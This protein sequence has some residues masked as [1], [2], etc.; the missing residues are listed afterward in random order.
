MSSYK[1]SISAN[2]CGCFLVNFLSIDVLVENYD[3][4]HCYY[5]PTTSVKLDFRLSFDNNFCSHLL[6]V[7]II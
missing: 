7:N 1:Y 3:V 5:F 2:Y 4:D 6:N